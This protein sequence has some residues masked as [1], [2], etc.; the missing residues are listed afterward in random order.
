[1]IQPGS[2]ALL[3]SAKNRFLTAGCAKTCPEQSR[4]NAEKSKNS[5]NSAVTW[6]LL[7]AENLREDKNPPHKN[8]GQAA[9]CKSPE[10]W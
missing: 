1:V 4:R 8:L 2:K 9:V 5:Q 3:K 6:P 7:R 10:L